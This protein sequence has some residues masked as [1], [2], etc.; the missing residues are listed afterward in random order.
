MISSLG[1]YF[2]E[3]ICEPIPISAQTVSLLPPI[4]K[5]FSKY[6]KIDLHSLEWSISSNRIFF[7]IKNV[8]SSLKRI[9]E[10]IK[11]P[12]TNS[13]YTFV[14]RFLDKYR[15]YKTDLF[16]QSVNEKEFWFVN[17][18]YPEES[19]QSI[20]PEITL[21]ILNSIKWPEYMKWGKNL[22]WIRPV[23][24]FLV[25]FMD[26]PILF[27]W[28]EA[29][30]MSSPASLLKTTSQDEFMF[31]SYGKYLQYLSNSNIFPNF[32]QRHKFAKAQV[33]AICNSLG[34]LMKESSYQMLEEIC[35]CTES[36]II[37][38]SS[39]E[40]YYD[41]PD[42]VV[43]TAMMH[44]QKYIPLFDSEDKLSKHF[45]VWS[46]C[47]LEDEGE[48]LSKD[49]SFCMNARLK[50]AKFFWLKDTSLT[51]E[52]YK[53]KM[54]S[55]NFLLGNL[56]QQATRVESLIREFFPEYEY[57][58]E[59]AKYLNFDLCMNL[60]FEFPELHGKIAA[61]Y[62]ARFC[63]ASKA[64]CNAIEW[65]VF[66]KGD[67]PIPAG[68]PIEA[69]ILGFCVRLDKIVG[70]I[71][72]GKVPKGSSDQ[73]GIRRAASELVKLAM[74]IKPAQNLSQMISKIINLYKQ[75]E[76]DMIS[77]TKELSI[78]F[79]KE[80]LEWELQSILDSEKVSCFILDDVNWQEL[81]RARTF[82]SSNKDVTGFLVS[83]YKRLTGV[84]EADFSANNGSEKLKI[85]LPSVQE[86][87]ETITEH[88]DYINTIFKRTELI[89]NEIYIKDLLQESQDIII[90][91]LNKVKSV[92]DKYMKLSQLRGVLEE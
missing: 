75:Q 34:L 21:E 19:I 87:F 1:E 9:S 11:G 82:L 7:V 38:S 22:S 8:P 79:I 84:L 70:S 5:A 14:E 26:A 43:Q 55:W 36:P 89:L 65:S 54:R 49:A 24:R 15:E 78:S 33:D 77:E 81:E 35:R 28:P 52:D 56:T 91:F 58:S 62:A 27:N 72:K 74:R 17:V 76:I 25:M 29:G 67:T 18:E 42:A 83:F 53:K 46:N 3:V 47:Y 68:M 80:R 6:E 12:A 37:Y 64:V 23:R 48:R 92:A 41:L 45:L 50:D 20:L 90:Y 32:D 60:I 4:S 73:L 10:T 2:V 51:E 16:K 59:A 63:N 66:P 44:H 13:P 31:D 88:F 61:I 57:I 85:D 71:G 69:M 39:V 40:T 86:E 30:L